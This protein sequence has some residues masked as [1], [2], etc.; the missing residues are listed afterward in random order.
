MADDTFSIPRS[1]H[2][3]AMK[4]RVQDT[5]EHYWICWKPNI[6]QGCTTPQ[7][8]LAFAK[9]PANLEQGKRLREWLGVA[10]AKPKPE[11][12]DSTRMVT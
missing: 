10:A 7:E 12:S 1:L 6:T 2:V 8:V 9:W 3:T 4:L 5:V 11:P